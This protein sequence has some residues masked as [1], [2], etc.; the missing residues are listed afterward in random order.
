MKQFKYI[1]LFFF[2]II[3][4][5]LSCTPKANIKITNSNDVFLS[6][7]I[8]PSIATKK[9]LKSISNFGSNSAFSDKE[10]DVSNVKTEDGIEIIKLKKTS[11]LDFSAKLKFSKN[12]KIFSSMFTFDKNNSNVKFELNRKT[13]NNFLLSLAT[14]DVEYLELLMAPSL[15]NIK[16]SDEEYIELIA[17]SYGKK[18]ADELKTSS[19]TLSIELPS[20]VTDINLSPKMDYKIKEK[21]IIFIIPLT[22]ILIMND[23]ISIMIDYSKS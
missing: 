13:L 2:T 3:S 6:M 19:L 11:S 12:T 10:E 21:E 23:P 5:F 18:I 4:F 9:L 1:K 8:S 14:E 16:M 22:E 20:K 15:Q 17:S 7:D